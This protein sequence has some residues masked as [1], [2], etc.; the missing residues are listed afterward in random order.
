MHLFPFGFLHA[1]SL[2]HI[3]LYVYNTIAVYIRRTF[4]IEI[5][6]GVACFYGDLRMSTQLQDCRRVH[7][8]IRE[9]RALKCEQ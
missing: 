5:R 4:R 7:T 2:G 8:T 9:E 3:L 6:M 1:A